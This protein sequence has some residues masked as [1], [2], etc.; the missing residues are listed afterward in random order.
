MDSHRLKL[1]DSMGA[2]LALAFL[3]V[4]LGALVLFGGLVLY[5]SSQDVSDLT[6]QQQSDALTAVAHAASVAYIDAGGWHGAD[7][8]APITLATNAG[9]QVSVLDESGRV[10]AGHRQFSHA[11]A[12]QRK[13]VVVGGSRVGTVR[14]AFRSPSTAVRDLRHA[15]LDTVLA[16]AALAAA[17]ALAVSIAVARRITRPV[18][19]LIDA[20]RAVGGGDRTARVPENGHGG[21][22]AELAIAF[23]RMADAIEHQDEVRRTLVA[24]VAH[25][26]RT[27]LTVVRAT[28]EGLIDGATQT[29]TARLSSVHDD[30]LRLAKLVEDLE[31]LAAADAAGPRLIVGSVDLAAVATD[32]SNH[33]GPQFE[34]A[35]LQLTLHT[36]ETV[37][38]GDRH[39]L[40]Q[41]VANLLTNALKFTPAGGAVTVVVDHDADHAHVIVRDTGVG[42]PVDEQA[43]VFE[44]FWRGG[45]SRGVAGSGIGLTV[46]NELVIAHRG[47]VDLDSRPGHGTT[48]T[49]TLPLRRDRKSGRPAG[50]KPATVGAAASPS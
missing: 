35:D 4:A 18:G 14:L 36:E 17:L 22:L 27:P 5:A 49:V 12:V 11:T 1:P 25:E 34:A 7:L 47:S 3:A 39:R 33:F 29:T 13:R 23:N 46:V 44:R 50:G 30:I 42:I 9:A 41:V 8:D 45:A 32:A 2:R 15:L 38:G 24:D 20:A 19:A 28:L 6:A 10:V 43:Q 37:V 31:M 26:L 40:D 21:E 48:V 16:A